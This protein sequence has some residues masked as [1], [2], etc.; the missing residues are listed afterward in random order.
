MRAGP[1]NRPAG[2][3]VT[4]GTSPRSSCPLLPAG[5]R[6]AQ[7]LEELRRRGSRSGA[8]ASPGSCARTGSTASAGE[9]APRHDPRRAGEQ[10]GP[11]IS[12]S[13]TSARGRRTRRVLRHHLR[14]HVERPLLPRLHPRPGQ[15]R[16]TGRHLPAHRAR[17][18]RAQDRGRVGPAKRGLTAHS[19]PGPPGDADDNALAETRIAMFRSELV[20]GRRVSSFERPSIRARRPCVRRRSPAGEGRV[21]STRAGLARGETFGLFAGH[22]AA[23]PGLDFAATG[24]DAGGPRRLRPASK[25]VQEVY[26][27]VSAGPRV[28]RS[29]AVSVPGWPRGAETAWR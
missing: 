5:A 10:S 12:C 25:V 27:A 11:A 8:A 14:P 18:R 19:S 13:A 2:H 21:S 26:T 17:P 6:H 1:E 23:R 4:D 3:S 24:R 22:S 28:H 9:E 7:D 29:V 16:L 20:D 15:R